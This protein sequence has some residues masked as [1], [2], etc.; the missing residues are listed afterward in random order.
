VAVDP[1]DEQLAIADA[2][3]TRSESILV[4]AYAGCAK[5]TTLTLAARNIKVPALA[6]AFNKRNAEDLKPRFAG[7]FVVR[8][9]NGL[10]HLAW[11]R[12]NPRVNKFEIDD[13]KLSKLI[14]LVCKDRQVD[15]AEEQWAALRALVQRAMTQ[16]LVPASTGLPGLVADDADGWLAIGADI[17]LDDDDTSFL[18][19]LAREIL[20]KDIELARQ[21]IISFDDQV[22]C[23]AMLGGLFPK[24]PVILTDETQDFAPLN[25]V[26]LR[27]ALR[28]DARL[29]SVGDEKQSVYAFRGADG[30]AMTTAQTLR[31]NWV[32]L[33]LT[34]TFRCPKLVVGRQQ[35]H[36]PGFR[37]FEGNRQGRFAQWSFSPEDVEFGA[38]W[39]WA[40]V[41]ALRPVGGSLA[42]LCRNNGPLIGLAFR[43]LRRNI[44]CHVLGRDILKGV[45][46][47]IHKL[48][49]DDNVSC[50][51][52]VGRLT[53]WT[54]TQVALALAND[55]SN[56]VEQIYDKAEAIR[57]AIEGA[58]AA[59]VKQ[60]TQG[61]EALFAKTEGRVTLASI[62]RAK[63]AEW[64]LV[65]HLDWWRIPSRWATTAIAK[66][67]ESNLR[68]VCET[69]TRD[70]LVLASLNE[71]KKGD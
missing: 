46:G 26:M 30:E 38:G 61:L 68:Y 40:E 23:S 59:T 4:P 42:V 10:G 6:L 37:A 2:A 44:P 50:E 24:Y 22:Y 5:T 63:G 67:Q 11:A 13:R 18:W 41:E 27:K 7:N 64:D 70:V 52:L 21:G 12:G 69:R 47:L 25:F 51:T 32:H 49:P 19:E 16:G 31:E 58:Q 45:V 33:P 53:E 36:A 60:L 71:M 56:K 9:L 35:A 57:C 1:T 8:T 34:M 39:T 14:S 48:C 29:M 55:Q 43:L 54:D 28:P 65:V 66:R 3:K 20:E 17:G 15:L 62:H